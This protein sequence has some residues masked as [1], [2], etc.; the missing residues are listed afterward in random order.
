MEEASLLFNK[1]LKSLVKELNANLTDA[2][3]IYINYYAIGADSSVLSKPVV[4][5]KSSLVN[6]NLTHRQYSG[7]LSFADF[8]DSSTGCCPVSSDGECIENEVPCKN[9]TEYAFWDSY[10]PT[11][12]VNKFIATSDAYPFDIRHL[13][14]LH[15]QVSAY[16]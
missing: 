4:Q 1:K 13:V 3:F 7:L 6:Y 10:H 14:M 9:R 8:K 15:L 16:K 2:K 5:K 12:A 11:E